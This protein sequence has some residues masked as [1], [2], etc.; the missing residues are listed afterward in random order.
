MAMIKKEKYTLCDEYINI[1][2]KVLLKCINGHYWN[3][4]PNM[5]KL[6]QRCLHC[7]HNES[8]GEKKI[9]ETLEQMK[10]PF[11]VQMKFSFLPDRRCDFYFTYNDYHFVTE[12]DG[13]QH[14]QYIPFFHGDIDGFKERQEVDIMLMVL[15]SLELVIKN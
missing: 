10:I 14:F 3:V 15:E 9:K 2:I 4:Q 8:K 12:F 6:R 7:R 1:Q 11:T 13:K 5:F